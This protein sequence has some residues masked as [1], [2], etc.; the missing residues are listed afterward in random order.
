[1]CPQLDLDT[2]SSNAIKF[3]NVN[4]AKNPTN[5]INI[6]G[7]IAP[8]VSVTASAIAPNNSVPAIPKLKH[9]P[10]SHKHQLSLYPFTSTKLSDASAASIRVNITNAIIPG[11]N[12]AKNAIAKAIAIIMLMATLIKQV[13]FLHIISQSFHKYKLYLH[14][15]L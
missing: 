3:V 8:T 15:I 7:K 12:P 13:L 5:A 10:L 4:P 2:Q 9:I 6:A 14:Y 1:M 11:N